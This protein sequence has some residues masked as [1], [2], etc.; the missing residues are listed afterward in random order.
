VTEVALGLGL[1]PGRPALLPSIACDQ[2]DRLLEVK[3]FKAA[4]TGHFQ[5]NDGQLNESLTKDIAQVCIN[6]IFGEKPFLGHP[7]IAEVWVT[8]DR[9]GVDAN[10]FF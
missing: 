8:L 10:E 9:W 2:I 4:C 1:T 5:E 7:S 3:H 6:A